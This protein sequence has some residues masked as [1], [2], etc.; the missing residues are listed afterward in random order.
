[1]KVVIVGAG[2]AGAWVARRLRGENPDLSITLIGEE[3][4]A[5]YERPPLSKA[6]ITG[7]DAAPSYILSTEQ[8]E[9]LNIDLRLGT[10]ATAIDRTGKILQLGNG[11]SLA[12]DKLVL[13]TG[14]RARQLQVPGSDLPGI[15]YLRTWDDALR[16]RER[17]RP[18]KSIMVVGGGWIGLELASTARKTGCEVTLLESAD[19]LCGRSVTPQISAFLAQQHQQHGVSVQFNARLD[20][21][22]AVSD[23]RLSVYTASGRTDVD[24]IAVGIGLQPETALAQ[25]AGLDIANGIV[26]DRFGL[27]SDPDIYATGDVANQPFQAHA[28]AP[29]TR[30]R[31]ESYANATNHAV[32]VA[33]HI[34][35]DV[36]K[37]AE[38]PWFWSDQY[39]FQ[40][41]VLGTPRPDGQ[42]ILRGQM[43]DNK[44]CLFQMV[45]QTVQAVI[46]VNMAKELKIAKRWMKSGCYPAPELLSNLSV[47][48]EKI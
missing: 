3:A 4:W 26:V 42:W 45:G 43:Q 36:E 48:L 20:K 38:I 22:E 39:D 31:F 21:I 28:S 44:F 10:A 7:G 41:Q 25:D 34:C 8:A 35:G 32:G 27:T 13:A 12:Y 30:M 11:K 19:C 47:R 18:G 24:I 37:I 33:D 14:G 6:S 15:Y 9:E 46:A 5:P 16:L 1:M 17:L 2:Q 40:L 29:E 23:G